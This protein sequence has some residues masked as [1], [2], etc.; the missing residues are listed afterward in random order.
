[1][2]RH[3]VFFNKQERAELFLLD[4]VFFNK[5]E[6]AELFLLTMFFIKPG[7]MNKAFDQCNVYSFFGSTT[8]IAEF[9]TAI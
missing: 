2:L 8:L 6:R 1:M 3:D 7:S 9:G 4:V 5:N